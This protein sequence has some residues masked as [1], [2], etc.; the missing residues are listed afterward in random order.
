VQFIR[1]PFTDRQIAAFKAPGARILVGFDH[2]NYGHQA[3]LP[4]PV[5]AALAKDFD[6]RAF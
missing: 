5:R 2:P 4:D 3:T 6:W 1:F